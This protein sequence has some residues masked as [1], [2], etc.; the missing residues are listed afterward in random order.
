MRHKNSFGRAIEVDLETCLVEGP[1]AEHLE[2]GVMA[3][4]GAH[5]LEVVVLATNPDTLSQRKPILF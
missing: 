1:A 4:V 3:A 2:E 5:N